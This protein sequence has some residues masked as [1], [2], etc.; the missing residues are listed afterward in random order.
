MF[1]SCPEASFHPAGL[2]QAL[3]KL[4]RRIERRRYRG[5]N[6]EFA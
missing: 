5:G 2:P 6:G 3:R 1:L 4:E